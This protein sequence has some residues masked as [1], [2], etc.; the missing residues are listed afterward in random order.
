MAV[1]GYALVVATAVAV[2]NLTFWRLLE[3][4]TPSGRGTL[5]AVEGFRQF[6][7]AA[8]GKVLVGDG[9]G[10]TDAPPIRAEHLPYAIALGADS[11]RA[12]VLDRRAAWYAGTSGGFSVA[13]F[14]ASLHRM[15]PRV[16]RS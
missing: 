7:E 11:E 13:D 8:C 9:T 15:A 1:Y 6:L 2:L 4:P 10:T 5:D 16:A 12:A 3:A 14:T